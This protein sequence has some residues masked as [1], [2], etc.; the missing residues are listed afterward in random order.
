[1]AIIIPQPCNRMHVR[2]RWVMLCREQMCFFFFRI[3]LS[4]N[5]HH[6]SACFFV[7]DRYEL[8]VVCKRIF[9]DI[10]LFVNIST[11]RI[12]NIFGYC[13]LS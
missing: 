3:C 8:T 13:L 12:N 10:F 2:I 9:F 5:F 7:S 4:D 6:L 1:M 11:S